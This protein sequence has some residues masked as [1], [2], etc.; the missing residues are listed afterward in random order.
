VGKARAAY[1][2]AAKEVMK[3]R[4]QMAGT[5]QPSKQLAQA[6]ESA[7]QKTERLSR[8]LAKQRDRLQRSRRGGLLTFELINART[9]L[10]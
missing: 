5:E 8:S 1:N 10:A 4:K 6:F 9:K 2:A 7:K 3:L